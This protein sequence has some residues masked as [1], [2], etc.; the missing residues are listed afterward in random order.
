MKDFNMEDAHLF[1]EIGGFFKQ[2]NKIQGVYG[3]W[4]GNIC[5]YIGSSNN[6]WDRLTTHKKAV[7]TKDIATN[8]KQW[9]KKQLYEYIQKN[10]RLCSFTYIETADIANTEKYLIQKYH[11]RFNIQGLYTPYKPP[12]IKDVGY[13]WS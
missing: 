12:K 9:K 3:I 5:L 7:I 8:K 13:D 4:C 10:R 6:L 11:P 2:L 1:D